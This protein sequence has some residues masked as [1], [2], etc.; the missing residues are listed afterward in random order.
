MRQPVHVFYGGAHLYKPG[1]LAKMGGLARRALD[2]FVAADDPVH[3]R[4]AAKLATEPIED[5][6]VDFE[7]GFGLRPDAEED[8]YA[9]SLEFAER[10]AFFGVRIK[11][12]DALTRE[13]ARRTLGLLKL[14]P[15]A[16]ITL[17]K[18]TSRHQP[19]ELAGW[20]DERGIDAG[21]ELMLETPESVREARVLVEACG[22]RCVAA[23]FGAYD[24]LSRLG[25]P[26]PDQA[27]T[28]PFCDQARYEIQ[29]A[30]VGTGVR[31]ADGVTTVFPIDPDP[32]PG[33]DLHQ[34]HVRHSLSQG[35]FTSWD[36]HPAQVAARYVALYRYFDEHAA[37]LG[38][39]LKNL[40][41][42][43]NQ[44]TRVGTSFDDAATAEGIVNFFA[45][46]ASC[47]ALDGEAVAS[48]AGVTMEELRL[49]SFAAI[50]AGRLKR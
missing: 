12:L 30:L 38:A 4:V 10:P 26:G 49:G 48:V 31:V 5:L 22:G 45:R 6:R 15:G 40:F 37:G 17:P 43:A 21:I 7:D 41:E 46:A 27:L 1:L 20:L 33:W 36:L 25:V 32:Q 29:M 35:Y 23:H 11:S 2:R 34:R 8:H 18:I 3:A 9:A 24:F 13:R 42:Q 44:A 16:I 39:R 50:A 47:G 28:H 19:A 14:P